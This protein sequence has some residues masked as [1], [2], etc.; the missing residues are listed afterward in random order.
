MRLW[1]RSSATMT[2]TT[3]VVNDGCLEHELEDI[4][5]AIG[6]KKATSPMT[7]ERMTTRIRTRP[8]ERR[9]GPTTRRA[10]NTR[11]GARG[12]HGQKDF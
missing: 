5:K 1:R 11:R 2:W 10:V 8:R 12:R 4:V 9:T 6:N 3:G 7:T